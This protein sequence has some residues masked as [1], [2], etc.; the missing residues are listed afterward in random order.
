MEGRNC[1]K[2]KEY[3]P[4]K[5]FSLAKRGINGRSS[6]C[7][8]CSR[9]YVKDWYYNKGGKQKTLDYEKNNRDKANKA[10]SKYQSKMHPGVYI[11]YTEKGRYIGESIKMER[12][13][14]NH[15]PWNYNSPVDTKILKWEILEVV[16][17]TQLRK[18]R[19]KYWIKKLK[20]ELNLVHR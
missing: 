5:D 2:C 14:W 6:R 15:K 18:E 10:I 20:P 16:E 9:L 11:V 12:R 17:D 3:K 19:E 13:V 8:K 1:T 7:R 4:W